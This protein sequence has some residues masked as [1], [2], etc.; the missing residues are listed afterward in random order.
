VQ[1]WYSNLGKRLVKAP[2]VY[3]ADSGLTACLLGLKNHREMLGH[4]AAGAVWEQIVLSNIRGLFPNAEIC[5]LPL[6]F[7]II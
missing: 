5:Y 7:P 6:L 1:P 2:K 4:P 3:I